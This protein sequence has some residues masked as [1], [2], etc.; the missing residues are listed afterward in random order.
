MPMEMQTWDMF[1]FQTQSEGLA[2]VNV[3]ARVFITQ[4]NEWSDWYQCWSGAGMSN[5]PSSQFIQ[6]R[7]TFSPHTINERVQ[8]EE[9][10]SSA[11][12]FRRL[13]SEDSR[14]QKQKHSQN[15]NSN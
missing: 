15:L 6:F 11:Y 1:K 9:T 4:S 14:M 13:Y 10:A 3:D 7:V 5:L 12:E 8:I 2:Y